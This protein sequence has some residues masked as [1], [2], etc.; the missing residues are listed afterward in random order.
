MLDTKQKVINRIEQLSSLAAALSK[1]P[2]ERVLQLRDELLALPADHEFETGGRSGLNI[3]GNPL[4]FCISSSAS[5]WNG[6]FISDP[7]CIIG[8]PGQ[9]YRHSYTALQNLYTIT[10]TTEIRQI[11]EEMLDFHLPD[12]TGPLEDYPDGVLWLGASPDMNGLAVYMDG[13]RGGNKAS[14]QRLQSW[15]NQIMPQNTEVDTFVNNASQHGL[16]MSIGLEGSTMENLRAKIY[17]RLVQ[18]TDLSALG[19]PLLLRNEFSSFMDDVVG[20][21][22]I[23]Q[24]GLVFNIGFHIASGKMFDA[25][26]DIC[27]CDHCVNRDAES[28]LNVL[29]HTAS[30]YGIAPFPITANVLNEQCAISYYGIGVDRRG[31]IRMN[32]YLKNKIR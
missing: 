18:P 14:W 17:F 29:E 5:G 23:K 7:A 12:Q 30:R 1:A 19:I 28:W 16:I 25:K 6:R 13:R 3:D 4:Q 31:E 26:I 32:L 20:G 8:P 24:A 9:R 11:C 22:Q 21:K 15:L 2:S 27:G 10:G